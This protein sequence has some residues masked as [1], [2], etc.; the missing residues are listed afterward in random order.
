MTE[1]DPHEPVLVEVTR[2]GMVESRHRGS[3][4]LLGADGAVLRRA[5][6]PDRPVY[7]RSANKA[8]QAVAMVRA[9]LDL[10]DEL[11]AVA[12]ASHSG[13]P[14][15]LHA[16]R[17][18]LDRAGLGPAD[19]GNPPGL[20]L[21]PA[22]LRAH[23]A[24]GG[25]EETILHN[26]SGKHA[27]MLA[28]CVA[29][30]WPRD[31]YLDPEHPLQRAVTATIA[32]LSGEPVAHIG[33]DGCGAP[34][35]ALTLTALARAQQRIAGA[36]PD[37]TEGRV[38]R[39]V[40]ARPELVGG[41]GRDDTRLMRTLPGAMAKDGA[42]G[43]LVVALA[44]GPSF[45]LKLAD[46]AWRGRAAVA[47]DWLAGAGV[48]VAAAVADGL[49]GDPVTGGGRVVGRV[50]GRVAGRVVGRIGSVP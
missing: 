14:V 39:A 43:V 28:T 49:G 3:A 27:A 48:D 38:A 42:E 10:P 30:G 11:L 13:E 17:S 9:G 44:D 24:R 4:V 33:V 20:P 45:A 41:T 34:A 40:R 16:V 37:T 23:L 6:E 50:V 31:G 25:G 18:I 15:H 2:S 47:L 36:P 26:C 21:G 22:E 5:G 1:G 29:A 8:M 46:G 7:P 12:A 32:E 19:L 35:H